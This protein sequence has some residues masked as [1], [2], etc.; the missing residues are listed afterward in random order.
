MMFDGDPRT[1]PAEELA[2]EW[3]YD[4]CDESWGAVVGWASGLLRDDDDD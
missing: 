2:R 3:G 4:E 1:E